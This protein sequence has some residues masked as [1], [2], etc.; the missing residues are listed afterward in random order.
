MIT[1]CDYFDLLPDASVC[2]ECGV[3]H[4]AYINL[5]QTIGGRVIVQVDSRLHCNGSALDFLAT[6]EEFY[7]SEYFTEVAPDLM[8][9]DEYQLLK[10]I[11]ES[12]MVLWN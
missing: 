5:A 1:D 11:L 6:S 3:V 12:D 9:T 7:T 10:K 8:R 2:T 4:Y